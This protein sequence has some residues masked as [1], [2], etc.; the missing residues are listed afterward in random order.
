MA[1]EAIANRLAT[2][3]ALMAVESPA[4]TLNARAVEPAGK[5]AFHQFVVIGKVRGLPISMHHAVQEEGCAVPGGLRLAGVWAERSVRMRSS[6]CRS[7]GLM[8]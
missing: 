3:T 1:T 6:A 7:T 5:L 8:R 2:K 4:Y